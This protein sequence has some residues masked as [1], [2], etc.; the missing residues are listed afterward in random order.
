MTPDSTSQ[1]G[2]E[3]RTGRY[4]AIAASDRVIGLIETQHLRD[5]VQGRDD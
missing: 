2:T 3:A 5:R 1:F 4:R